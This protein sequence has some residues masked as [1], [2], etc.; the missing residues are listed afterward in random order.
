[1]LQYN[2]LVILNQTININISKNAL[3]MGT[4]KSLTLPL[5]KL[6]NLINQIGNTKVAV[7]LLKTSTLYL[8]I[9]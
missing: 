6:T 3:K 1:M 2:L 4:L 7:W 9:L 8:K 5:S